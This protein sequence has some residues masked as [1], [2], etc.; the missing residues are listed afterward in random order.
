[1]PE[2]TGIN[3]YRVLVHGNVL[4]QETINVYYYGCESDITDLTDLSTAFVTTV[5]TPAQAV[6]NGNALFDR[7][8][9]T[10]VKGG[11][12]FGSFSTFV[13]GTISGDCLP[14][15]ASWDFTYIRAGAGERNGYKRL[16]GIAESSQV[17]G[18]ATSGAAANLTTVASGMESTLTVETFD[19]VP[20]IRRTRVAKLVQNPP[21]YYTIGGVVYSKIGTQNSRKYGHGR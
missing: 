9:I 5:L 15:Y 3:V 12:I 7:I 18:A 13:V 17:N 16:A 4:S 11:N 14:P 10:Q 21:K 8:D 20:V 19:V 1:M 6:M 2:Y